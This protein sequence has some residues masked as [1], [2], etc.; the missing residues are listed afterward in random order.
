[1]LRASNRP[2][3]AR[4]VVYSCPG[5]LADLEGVG[6]GR[7]SLAERVVAEGPVAAWP[8]AVKSLSHA[9]VYFP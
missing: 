5:L 8:P 2:G 4:T 6:R 9:R 7:V 1:M 3:L